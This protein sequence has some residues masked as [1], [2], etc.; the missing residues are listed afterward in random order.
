MQTRKQFLKNVCTVA[1]G[2]SMLTSDGLES[3]AVSSKRKSVYF[4]FHS[5]AGF[6]FTDG[7]LAI[8]SDT[9]LAKT[10][11]E[12]NEGHLT[13]GFFSLVADAP[14]LKPGPKGITVSG[15]YSAG[16]GWAEYKRQ[17]NQLKDVFNKVSVPLSTELSDLNPGNKKPTGYIAVEGG[18]FLDGQLKKVEEA[19]EDGV[20]SIQLVHYAPND[21]GDLQTSENTFNGLSSFGKE[22]VRKMNEL[23]MAIDVAHASYQTTKGVASLTKAP[24]ILSHSILEMDADRPI[25]KRAISKDHAKLVADT[26]GVIGA[27]PSGFNKSF[28]EYADNIKRLVDVTGIDHVGIGTDM[29]IN[30]KPVLSSYTQ[31]PQLAEALKSKGLSQTE[32]GK[33]MGDNAKVV[34][35]KIFRKK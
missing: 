10:I 11:S 32:V 17:L 16:D 22:I 7:N 4:D 15:K 18:D 2:S 29:N 5:H 31:Y 8:N 6:S 35:S 33:I 13:G 3:F 1:V 24:I 23:G 12:M 19:Y 20:R 14:L 21:V 27:W 9:M 30:F 28:D 25:A 34:L 26:G